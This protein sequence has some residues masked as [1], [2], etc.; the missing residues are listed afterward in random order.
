MTA[1]HLIETD[2]IVKGWESAYQ[3]ILH[4]G[5][6][7]YDGSE[8]LKELFQ[9]SLQIQSPER[10]FNAIKKEIS[11]HYTDQT[12]ALGLIKAMD[13]SMMKWMHDLFFE[14]KKVPEL[15]NSWSYGWR[16]FAYHGTDQIQWIIDRL[17]QKPAAKSATI[18]M[19]QTAGSESYIPCISLL[20]FKIRNEKLWLTAACRSLDFGKKALLNM[21]NLAQ[22]ANYVASKVSISQI[23]LILHIMSAHIYESEWALR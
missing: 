2:S 18:S 11:A 12:T 16:L 6:I 15:S 4:E 10:D 3:K 20:D 17:K 19:L 22:I 23:G 14:S 5:D 13:E 7:I 9:L 1:V 21:V 8:R